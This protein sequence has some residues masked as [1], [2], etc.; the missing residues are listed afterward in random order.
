MNQI[1]LVGLLETK[2]KEKK[3]NSIANNIFQGWHW[4]HTFHLNP[5]GRIWIAWQPRVFRVQVVDMSEQHIHCKATVQQNMK[6][7]F[8]TFVYGAN[9]ETN[10]K[11]LWT[12]LTSIANS[13]IE[14]W[15]VLGDFNSV[16]YAGDRIGGTPIQEYEIRPFAEC[17]EVCEL[18]EMRYLCSYYSWTNK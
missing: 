15:C 18:T 7:F 1:R 9:H 16:L 12:A 2:V 14:P 6:Q 4:Y 10:R 8:I 5:K 3:V 11:A 17:I 13:L